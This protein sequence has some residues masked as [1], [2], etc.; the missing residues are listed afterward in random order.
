MTDQPMQPVAMQPASLPPIPKV[1]SLFR[2]IPHPR[3][4]QRKNEKPVKVDDARVGVNG[5]VAL[6]ITSVV[7]TMWCAY[8]FAV[9]G[10]A[11]IAA[12][13]SNSVTVVLIVGAVSGYGR[14]SP[15]RVADIPA[16]TV[17][18]K[19][20]VLST[21]GLQGEAFPPGIPVGRVTSAST[22]TGALQETVTLAPLA[23]PFQVTVVQVLIWSSQTPPPAG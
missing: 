23:D 19:G 13:V 16:G 12:A 2:H 3:I 5:K 21:S 14:G 1:D 8:V 7:G 6:I 9:I 20:E 18:S 11:G 4:A 10:T 22:A 17:I 15:L